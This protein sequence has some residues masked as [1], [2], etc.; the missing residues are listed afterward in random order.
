[1]PEFPILPNIHLEQHGNLNHL[2]HDNHMNYN[3]GSRYQID[4][5]IKQKF[6]RT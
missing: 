4:V 1:M 3:Y 6:F 2:Y 5:L